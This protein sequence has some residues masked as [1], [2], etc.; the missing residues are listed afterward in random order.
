MYHEKQHSAVLLDF[1][2]FLFEFILK[3]VHSEYK[4]GTKSEIIKSEIY[5]DVFII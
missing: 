1:V 2:L 3:N 4:L 5:F